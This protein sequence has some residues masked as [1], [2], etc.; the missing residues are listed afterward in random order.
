MGED[1]IDYEKKS[2]TNTF[3]EFY[4]VF[5]HEKDQK[6]PSFAEA[7]KWLEEKGRATPVSSG[8]N[9]G[10]S[11][12]SVL[13]YARI[14]HKIVRSR[15]PSNCKYRKYCKLQL[16]PASYGEIEPTDFK[17]G[18]KKFVSGCL[19]FL[20]VL[21]PDSLEVG[22][23]VDQEE[24]IRAAGWIG[25]IV[26]KVCSMNRVSDTEFG[27]L[28]LKPEH[29]SSTQLMLIPPQRVHDFVNSNMPGNSITML[30]DREALKDVLSD[31]STTINQAVLHSHQPSCA[32]PHTQ[33]V[34]GWSSTTTS[35]S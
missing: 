22:Q 16:V 31:F 18:D 7:E 12:P 6:A 14:E 2:G 33:L 23:L 24:E 3:V 11:L 8:S 35:I 20:T 28:P 34:S 5:G 27:K 32:E 15:F 13:S 25:T 30:Q 4:K 29:L 26:T 17:E 19:F 1:D 21:Y 9:I 10:S